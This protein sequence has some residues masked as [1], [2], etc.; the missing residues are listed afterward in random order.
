MT[1]DTR[2]TQH[3]FDNDHLDFHALLGVEPGAD[4]TQVDVAY[5]RLLSQ[6][7]A[8]QEAYVGWKL[9]R[10]RYYAAAY[11]RFASLSMMY[12]AGFI[13]DTKRFGEGNLQDTLGWR[14]T[15]VDKI[16]NR[17][18][19]LPAGEKGD[20]VLLSTGS[21]S[22]IHKGHVAIVETAKR[23]LEEHG[24]RVLGGY[25]SPSHD[26]YVSTKAS[27]RA[28]LHAEKRL[29]LCQLMAE[30]YDW[31]M[32]DGWEAL[33]NRVAVNFTDV[34]DRLERYLNEVVPSER[35]IK[36][37]YVFGADNAQFV[38][39]FVETGGAVCVARPGYEEQTRVFGEDWLCNGQRHWLLPAHLES[40]ISSTAVRE[41]NLHLLSPR[42][43]RAYRAFKSPAP[44]KES[45]YVIRDDGEQIR[46]ALAI[47][48]RGYQPSLLPLLNRLSSLIAQS[49]A[50]AG[51]RIEIETVSVQSQLQQA[52]PKMAAHEHEAISLDVY[53]NAPRYNIEL[54]RCFEL[55]GAQFR[56]QGLV[57]RPEVFTDL[58]HQLQSIE[59]GDYLLV[60]DDIASG[61]TLAFFKNLLPQG[62]RLVDELVL[63]DLG[64]NP[65]RGQSYH[66]IVD[67]RD[68]VLGAPHGGLV[69]SPDG[70]V[71]L[72]VPYLYPYVNLAARAKI[73]CSQVLGLSL[74]LWEMNRD[75]HLYLA[76]RGS[77][78][79]IDPSLKR[80]IELSGFNEPVDWSIIESSRSAG[81][82]L[83]SA[84]CQWHIEKLQDSGHQAL[85]I[86][87]ECGDGSLF[88]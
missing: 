58:S 47:D 82:Y 87:Q 3:Y 20:V 72:R 33:D 6:G 25:L 36:V 65:I 9:L 39:P 1:Q 57:S 88:G 52:G 32:A 10:D 63:S 73:P 74:S 26:E 68:F 71:N 60:E 18:E 16:L 61:Q 86:E 37:F 7:K 50:N 22:P 69:V 62:V 55:G 81:A 4:Q 11:R 67:L 70:Q 84:F 35:D 34:V 43:E 42:V 17:L 12:Q 5:A 13:L 64:D 40:D 51:Q 38:R 48:K 21:Y 19:R 80:L 79:P 45:R 14:S 53:L 75:F 49:F 27:G 76:Q 54:S 77:G 44:L 59:A 30:D 78:L 23:Y 85:S 56:P 66:D 28:A 83:L 41:G 31:L 24:Y 15:P 8:T 46:Q 2:C 29:H